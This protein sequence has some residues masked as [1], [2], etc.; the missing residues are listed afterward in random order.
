MLCRNRNS[1]YV[2]ETHVISK[3]VIYIGSLINVKPI[4]EHCLSALSEHWTTNLTDAS[5]GGRIAITHRV[6]DTKSFK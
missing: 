2:N 1:L 5:D 3:N 6:I 4:D